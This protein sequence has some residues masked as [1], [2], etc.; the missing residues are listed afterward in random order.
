MSATTKVR[1][2]WEFKKSMAHWMYSGFGFRAEFFHS[3][4]KVQ[5]R[6]I[7]TF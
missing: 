5:G 7:A 3:F 2:P 1:T 4:R 6:M